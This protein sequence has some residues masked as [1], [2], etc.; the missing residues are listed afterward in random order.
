[1]ARWRVDRTLGNVG[2]DGRHER[3]VEATRNLLSEHPGADVVLAEDHDLAV[4]LGSADGYEDGLGAAGDAGDDLWAGE[5][6]Q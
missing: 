2:D 6:L 4:L 1:M 3:L 5:L